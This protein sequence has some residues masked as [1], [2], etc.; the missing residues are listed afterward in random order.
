MATHMKKLFEAA[1]NS[2]TV[3]LEELLKDPEVVALL[4]TYKL[5][6]RHVLHFAVERG[7]SPAV[8]AALVTA[9]ADINLQSLNRH[10]PLTFAVAGDNREALEQLLALGANVDTPGHLRYTPLLLAAADNN[11]VL[12]HRLLAAGADINYETQHG[13]TALVAAAERNNIPAIKALLNA[14][15][16]VTAGLVAAKADMPAEALA[17]LDAQI[18]GRGVAAKM[19]AID[20]MTGHQLPSEI[21]KNIEYRAAGA[22]KRTGSNTY[23]RSGGGRR[24]KTH[25]ARR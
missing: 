23:R 11:V 18:R 24:R 13:T 2:D 20:R 15:A 16:A 9:G 6:N 4:N 10:T 17:F 1:K 22:K 25:K 8:V 14:G 3:V 7:G 19:A 12:I 5:A 21:L